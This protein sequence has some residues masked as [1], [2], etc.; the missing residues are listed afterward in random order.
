[1]SMTVVTI[2]EAVCRDMEMHCQLQIGFE[3]RQLN[4]IMFVPVS[5][6]AIVYIYVSC[7]ATRFQNRFFSTIL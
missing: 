4:N 2:V 7:G 6:Q 3:C 1:M 5:R